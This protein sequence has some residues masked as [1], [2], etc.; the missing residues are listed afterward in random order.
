MRMGQ[1]LL[2]VCL[3]VSIS[4]C[5]SRAATTQSGRRPAVSDA[6]WMESGKPERLLMSTGVRNGVIAT[7]LL[8]DDLARSPEE[9]IAEAAR[10]VRSEVYRA[11]LED[12][13]IMAAPSLM[14]GIDAQFRK[15]PGMRLHEAAAAVLA[16][17]P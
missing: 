6:A 13:P 10:F 9:E 5:A 1:G 16:G 15:Q 11:I 14:R 4:G 2:M 12:P 7:M 17:H 3:I 8:L